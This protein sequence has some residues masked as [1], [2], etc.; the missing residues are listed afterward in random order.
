M[1]D[2]RIVKEKSKVATIQG[3]EKAWEKGQRC[4]FFLHP[5]LHPLLSF[6]KFLYYLYLY[7]YF[8]IFMLSCYYNCS[9]VLFDIGQTWQ[10]TGKIC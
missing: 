5:V 7:T 1:G 9:C 2:H 4:I 3:S 8:V 6:H 10:A